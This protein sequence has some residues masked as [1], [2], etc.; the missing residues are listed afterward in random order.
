V[1]RLLAPQGEIIRSAW[2]TEFDDPS[3]L[4]YLSTESGRFFSLDARHGQ[5][6]EL[7]IERFFPRREAIM[8]FGNLFDQT[9]RIID[10]SSVHYMAISSDTPYRQLRTYRLG[11]PSC[12]AGAG[13][14]RPAP[15]RLTFTSGDSAYIYPRLLMGWSWHCIPL[16]LLLAAGI[17]MLA[18]RESRSRF[19]L[20]VLGVLV[21][22]LF[23]AV[24]LLLWRR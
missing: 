22:G 6:A 7:P 17:A 5:C 12:R 18:R 11:G 9:V 21:F 20:K 24:P 23:L 19:I 4:G 14:R 10:G 8:I 2:V 1:R 13:A 3:Y 16:C 15:C